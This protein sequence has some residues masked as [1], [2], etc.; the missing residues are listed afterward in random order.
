MSDEVV[1]EENKDYVQNIRLVPGAP[2]G[3]LAWLV[4]KK[5]VQNA[6]QAELSLFWVA[7]GAAVLAVII[8]VLNFVHL[9]NP[10]ATKPL[11]PPVRTVNTS[12]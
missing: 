8:F 5:I 9:P 1:F 12:L 10:N 11:G 2:K 7:V 3:L 6:R 4:Q